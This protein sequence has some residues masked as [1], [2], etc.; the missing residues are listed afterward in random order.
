LKEILLS[1]GKYAIVDD[2]DFEK[3]NKFKWTLQKGRKTDY[4]ARNDMSSGKRKYQYLHRFIMGVS[5]SGVMVDHINHNGLDNR[6]ENLRICS[7]GQNQRNKGKAKHS[8]QPYKGVRIR[9][10][11]QNKYEARIRDN[12]V[13]YYLGRYETAREAAFAYDIAALKRFGEFAMTNFSQE[14]INAYTKHKRDAG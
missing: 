5:D 12:G 1:Q 8:K 14:E 4:A 3:V 11:L 9:R 13:E 7:N 2:E 10:T 6:K